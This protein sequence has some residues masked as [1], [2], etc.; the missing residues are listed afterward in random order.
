MNSTQLSL[1]VYQPDIPQNLGSM[2]RL[3][4]CFGAYIEIIGPC[5]FPFSKNVLKRT[6]MDYLEAAKIKH[7]RSYNSFRASIPDSRRIVLL[8]VHSAVSIWDFKFKLNDTI[9]VGRE[10]AGVPEQIRGEIS[11][12]IKIPLIPT[13]RCLN[14]SNAASIA[15][16]EAIRQQRSLRHL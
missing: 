14:V 7:H 9:M 16:A 6:A 3:C 1:A 2:I 15:L 13:V 5:G 4:A 10:S 8:T 11:D 12:K